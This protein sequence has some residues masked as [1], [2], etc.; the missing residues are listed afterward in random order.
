MNK[1]TPVTIVGAGLAGSECAWQ[2]AERGVQV[3]LHEMRDKISTEAHKTNLFA[4]LVCSNSF[5]SVQNYSAPGQLKWEAQRLGS[6]VLQSAQQ[7]FVPAGMALAVDR[8]GFSETITAKL[9]QHPNIQVFSDVVTCIDH[10]QRPAVIASGPLTHPD[11]ANSLCEFLGKDFFYFYDAI[12]PVVDAESVDFEKAFWADRYQKGTND[13]LN[14]P[15]SKVEYEAFIKELLEAEKVAL[16]TFEEAK[17]YEACMPVETLAERG[18]DSLRFGP[19]NPK[20]IRHP[21]TNEIFYAVVQ[22]R[23][24]NREKTAFNLVGFQTKLTY[25]E[26][27]RIFRMIPGLGR[28][29]FLKLGSV[30]RNSYIHSPILLNQ[31]FSSK[32]DPDLFFAGQLTG[33]EG[34]FE[35][36]CTGLMVG[37]FLAH[38]DSDLGLPPKESAFGALINH[39]T[40]LDK[41]DCFQPS[42]INFSLLPQLSEVI[43]NKR[44]RRDRQLEVA[45]QAFSQWADRISVL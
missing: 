4:E 16:R 2:L 43:K 7:H 17:Y 15:F 14:C 42:G 27:K 19:L 3:Y 1:K 31:N 34:Y 20:G 22:L 23:A 45:K 36:V 32:K 24:E 12:S 25:S 18:V 13:Y 11:L 29:E 30:H 21:E 5:G 9:K 40:N 6:I 44:N 38:K 10:V 37:I 39:V 8:K 26:Q 33:V 35:S 28:A 41:L